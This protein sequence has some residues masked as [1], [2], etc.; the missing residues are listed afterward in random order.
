M[1]MSTRYLPQPQF[2]TRALTVAAGDTATNVSWLE[3]LFVIVA[4]FVFTGPAMPFISANTSADATTDTAAGASVLGALAVAVYVMVLPVVLFNLR[5]M[6][7]TALRAKWLIVLAMLPT[8]SV[9][10]SGF[11]AAT[12]KDSIMLLL[13]TMFGVYVATRFSLGEILRMV[14]WACGMVVVLS[15]F[16]ALFLPSIGTMPGFYGGAW[17]GIYAH[18]NILA[19]NLDIATIAF[20]LLAL[21]YPRRWMLLSGLL[22]LT[23]GTIFMS[24]SATAIIILLALVLLVPLGR[25]VQRSRTIAGPFM[26]GLVLLISAPLISTF[27]DLTTYLGVIGKDETLT[28]RTQL[29]SFLIDMAREKPIL[30]YGYSGFWH[31]GNGPS[32]QVWLAFEW[33]PTHAHNG[34]LDLWLELGIVGVIVLGTVL[35]IAFRDAVIVART[36]HLWIGLWPLLFYSFVLMLNV[37]QSMLLERNSIFWLLLV[38]TVSS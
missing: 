12:L 28:G 5:A 13:T 33:L 32:G 8:V 4:L 21:S 31:A 19:R 16:T 14:A 36:E 27:A 1:N 34:L 17:R 26:I 24:G 3:R 2:G 22:V 35:A 20:I 18:K 15:I 9:I 29:W 10:W 11:P 23:V 30:G 7:D 25:V 37:P 38:A 6:I